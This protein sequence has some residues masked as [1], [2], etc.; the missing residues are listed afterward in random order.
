MKKASISSWEAASLSIPL[1]PSPNPRPAVVVPPLFAVIVR[2][3]AVVKVRQIRE[4]PF[5]L[6]GLLGSRDDGS[7]VRA[8]CISH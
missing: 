6:V 3:A 8:P 7:A 4:I 5:L 1:A 2:V